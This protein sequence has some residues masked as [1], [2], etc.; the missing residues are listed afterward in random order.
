MDT[1]IAEG[2][3]STADLR[4]ILHSLLY[5]FLYATLGPMKSFLLILLPITVRHDFFIIAVHVLK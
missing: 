2:L 4:F 5:M 3:A 1:V